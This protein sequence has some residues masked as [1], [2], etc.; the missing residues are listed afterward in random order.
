MKDQMT[1]R[2]TACFCAI[3]MLALKLVALPSILY[4][5]SESSGLLIAGA[6]FLF[7]LS[8]LLLFL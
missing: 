2:Q 3:S 4:E 1:V 8:C 6:L 7:D 5:K